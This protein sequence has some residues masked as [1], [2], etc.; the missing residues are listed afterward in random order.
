MPP[1]ALPTRPPAQGRPRP[2]PPVPS[3]GPP[4]ARQMSKVTTRASWSGGIPTAPRSEHRAVPGCPGSTVGLG[5][6][7]LS[8]PYLAGGTGATQ[9]SW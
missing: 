6:G 8:V 7:R 5:S 9:P 1:Q 4:G 3:Q 2:P